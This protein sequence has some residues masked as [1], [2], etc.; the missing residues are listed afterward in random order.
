MYTNLITIVTLFSQLISLVTD[1]RRQVSPRRKANPTRPQRSADYTS[2]RVRRVRTSPRE[3]S[4]RRR[5]ERHVREEYY[6]NGEPNVER[7]TKRTSKTSKTASQQPYAN[8]NGPI[9]DYGVDDLEED[10]QTVKVSRSQKGERR[11]HDGVQR[12]ESGRSARS[13]NGV[14][15]PQVTRSLM[16]WGLGSTDLD[17]G[18]VN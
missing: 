5:Q 2:E 11:D 4:P 14:I 8:H 1:G 9:M 6:G 18:R 3:P 15:P 16:V 10:F 7:R 17:N 12:S 13:R